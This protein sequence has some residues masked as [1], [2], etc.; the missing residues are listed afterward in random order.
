MKG[1][2]LHILKQIVLHNSYNRFIRKTVEKHTVLWVLLKKNTVLILWNMCMGILHCGD[3]CSVTDALLPRV[4][5]GGESVVVR[6]CYSQMV[7]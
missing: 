6:E 2:S 5:L 7:S 3:A 4:L 1:G